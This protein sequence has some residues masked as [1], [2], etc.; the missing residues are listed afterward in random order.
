MNSE[1]DKLRGQ[2]E[3]NEKT[4]RDETGKVVRPWFWDNQQLTVENQPV[5]GVSWFEANAY[6][7]WLTEVLRKNGTITE[8]DEIRI[9][10]E[11]EWEKAARGT[12]GRLWTWGNFWNSAFANTLEGR[13]M[14]PTTVGAYPRNTSPHGVEDMIGNVW[15]WC[16]DWYD[17]NEY[18]N[19]KDGIENPRGAQTVSTRVLRGGS[20]LN[21]RNLARCSYRNWGEPGSFLDN[22]GFRL[23]CS[24]SFPTLHSD[25]LD[26]ESLSS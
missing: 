11:S 8:K 7:E 14:Q 4:K 26:S 22:I 6:A 5:V 19:R 3:E 20:W 2:W 23:I 17:E 21:L 13:V 9:P 24:L 16:L 10:T 12:T 18:R 1:D 15:E 25:S